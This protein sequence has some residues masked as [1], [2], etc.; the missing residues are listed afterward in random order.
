MLKF[1][2]KWRRG[3][4]TPETVI[5]PTVTFHNDGEVL[6]GK[7]MLVKGFT[8]AL[9]CWKWKR[10][11]HVFYCKEWEAMVDLRMMADFARGK[12]EK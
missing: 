1:A 2:I 9:L 5:F 7:N 6:K 4:P 3:E 11:L 12:F 10:E 8:L